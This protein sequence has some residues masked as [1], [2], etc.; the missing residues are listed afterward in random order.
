MPSAT[1]SVLLSTEYLHRCVWP[2][3]PCCPELASL[4]EAPS[5]GPSF[6]LEVVEPVLKRSGDTQGAH[7]LPSCFTVRFWPWC[8]C[9]FVIVVFPGKTPQRPLVSSRPGSPICHLSLLGPWAEFPLRT[10]Q[11]QIP[12]GYSRP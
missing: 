7:V 8:F 10:P 3:L 5:A 2:V 1:R 12:R 4:P 6:R 11:E 9:L